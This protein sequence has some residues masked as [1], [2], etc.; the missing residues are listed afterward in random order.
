MPDYILLMHNDAPNET[1]PPD[2]G[3]YLARLRA[4]GVFQGGS[5]IGPGA[6]MRRDGCAWE[7][8]ERIGGYIRLQARDLDEAGGT[9]EVRELPRGD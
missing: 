8:S 5:A 2:W 1:A 3:A 4:E 6:C 9:A 7:I